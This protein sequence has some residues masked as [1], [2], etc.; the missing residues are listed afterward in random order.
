MTLST[1]P[2]TRGMLL[3]LFPVLVWSGWI[4]VSSYSVRGSLTAYD[5]TAI[6]FAVAGII[7][8]PVLFTRGLAI[9]PYGW[10]GSL[11]LAV[12]MGAPYSMVAVFGMKYAPAS[13]AASIINTT[14]LT[15][16]T[17]AGIFLLREATNRWRILGILLSVGGIVAMLLA[18]WHTDNSQGMLGHMLFI[19]GGLMW[20]CYAVSV[21]AWG[22]GP[23][24]AAAAV[25]TLSAV[26]YLPV[27]AL[28]LPSHI[29]LHNWQEVLFQGVYQGVINSVFA[30]MLFNRAVGILGA[31]TASAFLPLVPILATVFAIPALGEL[32]GPLE[33]AGIALAGL[34]VLLATGILGTKRTPCNAPVTGIGTGN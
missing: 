22:A 7:L 20:A 9:G 21:R 28:F 18:G 16:A 14:M 17:L 4:I 15:A 10:R 19:V 27:Y 12:T 34:G 3:I 11:W 30:L 13:H 5:I 32:P 31:G 24:H 26:F 29:S 2:R 8:A 6:R 25:C 33:W 23:L 1:T